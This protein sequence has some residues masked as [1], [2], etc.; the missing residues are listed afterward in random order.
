MDTA[1]LQAVARDFG[2]PD[3]ERGLVPDSQPDDSTLRILGDF[4]HQV[5][6]LKIELSQRDTYTVDCLYGSVRKRIL[7]ARNGSCTP[8]RP[9]LLIEET[10]GLP[11]ATD[12]GWTIAG[13][14]SRPEQSRKILDRFRAHVE[15]ALT[16]EG[17]SPNDIDAILLTGGPVKMPAV[18][19][20]LR[21]VFRENSKVVPQLD[22]LERNGFQAADPM[23]A[24]AVGAAM[25]SQEDPAPPQQPPFDYGLYYKADNGVVRGKVI[26][27]RGGG[28]QTGDLKDVR[29]LG[30]P[31]KAQTCGAFMREKTPDHRLPRHFLTTEAVFVPEYDPEV[32]AVDLKF[33]IDSS[34]LLALSVYDRVAKENAPLPA[35]DTDEY[36]AVAEPSPPEEYGDTIDREK[37]EALFRKRERMSKLVPAEKVDQLRY[38]GHALLETLKT[39]AGVLGQEYNRCRALLDALPGGQACEQGPYR[40]LFSGLQE[41]SGHAHRAGVLSKQDRDRFRRET[42]SIR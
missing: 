34:G 24:V 30:E 35:I 11:E 14:Q 26:I 16:H 31:G 32:A 5:E 8:I 38:L 33:S 29:W 12:P 21:C 37:I 3:L 25:F 36:V 13:Y 18:R 1:L 10:L 17:F 7:G 9:A 23:T 2:L 42:G 28:P 4:R 22:E 6:N 40:T 19:Q 41:L 27:G 15:F 39:D 20:V